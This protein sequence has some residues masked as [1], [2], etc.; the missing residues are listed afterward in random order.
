MRISNWMI[1]LVVALLFAG[2]WGLVNRPVEQDPWTQDVSGITYTPHREGANPSNGKEPTLAQVREDLSLMAGLTTQIRTYSSV[3][4]NF[5]IPTMADKMGLRVMAGAWIDKDPKRNRQEIDNL[6]ALAK[7]NGSVSR[8]TIGNEAI[9]KDLVTV[10]QLI[11]YIREVKRRLPD[12]PVGTSEPFD[13]W[14]KNPRLMDEVDFIG[15]HILPFWNGIPVEDA[16]DWT[17]GN[18]NEVVR[19]MKQH[20]LDK[21]VIL[22]EVGWPSQGLQRM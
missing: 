21:R 19:V 12:V 6:V 20:G 18:Y 3:G 9:F 14:L 22:N 2:T 11:G 15:V 10:D 5:G 16:V 7:N 4:A 1:G 17:L 13:I 8:V